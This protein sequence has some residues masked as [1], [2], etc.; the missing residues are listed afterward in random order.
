MAEVEL[1]CIMDGHES[2]DLV[3]EKGTC[4]HYWFLSMVVWEDES[5][6]SRFTSQLYVDDE[7]N[8]RWGWSQEDWL[9]VSIT[10]LILALQKISVHQVLTEYVVLY[11][12]LWKIQ[13][14]DCEL[15]LVSKLRDLWC[16]SFHSCL[17]LINDTTLVKL[18]MSQYLWD[19]IYQTKDNDIY[20]LPLL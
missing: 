7:Q 13:S 17:S 11:W 6:V 10:V 3:S 16:S 1:S 8:K 9:T 18:F 2:Q 15:D 20:I 14:R 12:A 4:S 5:S 19:F